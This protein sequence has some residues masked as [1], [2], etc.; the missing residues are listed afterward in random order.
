MQTIKLG[1]KPGLDLLVLADEALPGSPGPGEIRVRVAAS[2][3]NGHDYNVAVGRLPCA[4]GRTLLTDA[5]GT[6]EAVGEGVSEFAPGDAVIS[7]FFPLWQDG[8]APLADFSATP[9]DGVDGYPGMGLVAIGQASTQSR[10]AAIGIFSAF[11][12]LSLGISAPAMGAV[13]A[14]AGLSAVFVLAAVLALAMVPLAW[15]YRHAAR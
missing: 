6:V 2:S 7:C 3:L 13:A 10:G 9:G 15:R 1:E 12:D 8:D 5:A 4:A 11:L 14:A